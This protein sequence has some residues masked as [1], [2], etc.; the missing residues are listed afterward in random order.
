MTPVEQMDFVTRTHTI[1]LL[2]NIATAAQKLNASTI[3]ASYTAW[4]GEHS[5]GE[6]QELM[7]DMN[8]RISSIVY[9]W[10]QLP[11]HTEIRELAKYE[12]ALKALEMR[13]NWTQEAPM[14]GQDIEG[15]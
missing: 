8:I 14:F 11:E 6:L 1:T 7:D 5:D 15:S 12:R 9:N 2:D 10:M 4:K 3:T 13:R